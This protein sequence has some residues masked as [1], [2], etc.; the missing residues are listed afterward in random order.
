MENEQLLKEKDRAW[1]AWQQAINHF[2]NVTSKEDVD[3]AVFDMETK[4]RQYMRLTEEFRR[5]ES[6]GAASENGVP[7]FE[8]VP[9]QRMTL[10]QKLTGLFSFGEK[11]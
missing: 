2:N 11:R 9:E 10:W 4:R 6:A 7:D 3:L 5:K 8:S 1:R